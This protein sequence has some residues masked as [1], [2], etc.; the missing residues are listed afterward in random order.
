MFCPWTETSGKAL[1]VVFFYI[2]III[3][4]DIKPEDLQLTFSEKHLL[5]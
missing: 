1:R 4:L 3:I 2:I 5:A